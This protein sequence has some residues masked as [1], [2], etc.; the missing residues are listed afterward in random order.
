MECNTLAHC[1]LNPRRGEAN[2]LRL[3]QKGDCA[4]RTDL[5]CDSCPNEMLRGLEATSRLRV[6]HYPLPGWHPH[7]HFPSHAGP[8]TLCR[9]HFEHQGTCKVGYGVIDQ[10]H[11]NML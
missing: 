7:L 1:R 8:T 2:R 6:H 4:Q 9:K 10:V 5:R 11:V 3:R